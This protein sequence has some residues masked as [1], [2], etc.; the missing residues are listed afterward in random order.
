MSAKHMLVQAAM[1]EHG[2]RELKLPCST[3][4]AFSGDQ[5]TICP[6]LG[7]VIAH[8]SVTYSSR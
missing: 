3:Q 2:S 8:K 4:C 5:R 1:A 6:V 7:P